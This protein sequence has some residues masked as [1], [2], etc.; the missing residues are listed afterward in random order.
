M[1]FCTKGVHKAYV[2]AQCKKTCEVCERY[3]SSNSVAA[4]GG[5]GAGAATAATVV[6]EDK[7]KDTS[8]R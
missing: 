7:C 5:G 8:L 2:K 6:V 1:G 4:G 3:P